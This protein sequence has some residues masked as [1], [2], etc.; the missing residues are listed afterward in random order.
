MRPHGQDR[1]PLGAQAVRRRH[2]DDRQVV[3]RAQPADRLDV[4]RLLTV[5]SGSSGASV[6]RNGA[7]TSVS[8]VVG[9]AARTRSSRPAASERASVPAVSAA[10]STSTAAARKRAP[11]GRQD[12]APA[13]A[14]EQ[15]QPDLPLELL[16]L[17]GQR[18]LPDERAAARRRVTDPSSA[19]VRNVLSRRR[20]TP[21]DYAA[22]AWT[23]SPIGIG[24]HGRSR[25]TLTA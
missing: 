20:S 19:T 10:S 17:P 3:A 8:V 15:R 1:D 5:M 18:G 6:A 4:V 22:A 2:R 9:A 7:R 21:A 14:R 11:A 16:Q 13:L 24:R 23:A 12:Q 25:R